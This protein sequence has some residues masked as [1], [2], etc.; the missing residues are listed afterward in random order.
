V[1]VCVCV[2]ACAHTYVCK[3]Y[4]IDMVKELKPVNIR[5]TCARAHTHTHMHAYTYECIHTYT[6]KL[7]GFQ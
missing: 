2:W 6:D 7:P 1:C 5:Q 3:Y 4:N